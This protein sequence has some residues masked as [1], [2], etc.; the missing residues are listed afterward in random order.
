MLV[1]PSEPLQ[2]KH[3]G[4]SSPQPEHFGV[5]FLWWVGHERR[6]AGC[7]RKEVSDFSA[8][9]RDGRLAKELAQ[10]E[11]LCQVLVVIEGTIEVHGNEVIINDWT[12]MSVKQWQALIWKMQDVGAKVTGT[13]N[14][15]DTAEIITMF[16]TWTKKV[17][18]SSLS[19]RAGVNSTWGKP[20][21]REFALHLLQ[22]FEGVGKGLAERVYDHFGRVP[23]SWDVGVEGLMEVPGIGQ[24]KAQRMI[25]QLA[26]AER[27]LAVEAT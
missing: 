15:A 10:W 8:S 24:R 26:Q 6:F 25:G 22:G 19:A 18:H 4:K 14:Q 7:Q 17:A 3:L 13:V 20:T 16:Q 9:V 11:P 2:F 23:L 5:D 27:A 12:H 21:S 1:A